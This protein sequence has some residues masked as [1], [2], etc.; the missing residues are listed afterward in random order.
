MQRNSMRTITLFAVLLVAACNKT[1][2]SDKDKDEKSAK[3]SDDDKPEKKKAKKSSDDDDDKGEKEK[4]AGDDDGEKPEQMP[5][6]APADPTA[7]KAAATAKPGT[8]A[9]GTCTSG[10]VKLGPPTDPKAFPC[11]KK[12]AKDTDC[13][14]K[15][16]CKDQDAFG[17]STQRVCIAS[18]APAASTSA[19][20]SASAS[21]KPSASASAAPAAKMK[22]VLSSAPPCKAPYVASPKGLCQIPC[23]AGDC[24]ACGGTCQKGYCV[25]SSL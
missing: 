13:G 1:E 15:E 18:T 19:S 16:A 24:G 25:P 5:G 17:G 8:N 22:C 21:T 10:Y 6:E 11:F 23:P 20:T 4:K 12:C 2:S 14:A 7:K 9:D 3:E